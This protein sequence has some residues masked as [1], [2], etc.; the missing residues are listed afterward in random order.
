[1]NWELDESA[2]RGRGRPGVWMAA[3]LARRG[4]VPAV[5]ILAHTFAQQTHCAGVVGE[6]VVNFGV[7]GIAAVGEAFDDKGQLRSSSVLCDL[8]TNVVSSLI[9]PGMGSV[10]RRR[11]CPKSIS[12]SARVSPSHC[13]SEVRERRAL[14][15][16]MALMWPRGS[17]RPRGVRACPPRPLPRAR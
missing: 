10:S 16:K 5:G 17:E 1:M 13:L 12:S 14:L 11:W 3:E 9:P 7:E 8:D 2:R 4:H 6:C 15:R